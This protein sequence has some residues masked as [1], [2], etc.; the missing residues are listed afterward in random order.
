[1]IE[2]SSLIDRYSVPG[3]AVAIV[4]DG[5]RGSSTAG[6]SSTRTLNSMTVHD[7]LPLS[8]VMKVMVAMMVH[9]GKDEGLL[10]LDEDI[11]VFVPEL[12]PNP[13]GIT[14]RHLL[15]H[16]A[17]YIEPQENS[18]RWAYDWGRFVDFFPHRRQ[19]F[20]PG[21]AWSYTHTGYVLLAKTLEAV[22]K[23]PVGDLL[24]ERL[25]APLGLAAALYDAGDGAV[26]LHVRSPRTD[27]MEPMRPPAETGFLRYSIS[28]IAMSTDHLA[29]FAGALAGIYDARIPHLEAARKALL[30]PAIELPTFCHSPQSELMPLAYRLG[31]ADYGDVLGVNGSYVGST[32]SLRFCP[33]TRGGFAVSL[34]AWSPYVRDAVA[35]RATQT[36][37][38]LN[39]PPRPA[40]IDRIT[41]WEGRY[42]GLMLGSETATMARQGEALICHVA[43]KGAP[44]L[45]GQVEIAPDGQPVVVSGQSGLTLALARTGRGEPYLMVGTSAFR[46]IAA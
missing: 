35:A 22:F 44:A 33:G 36:L 4:K 10:A 41:D 23:Q 27:R 9:H 42:E 31:V 29:T 26:D 28:D 2:L 7:R 39:P 46:K 3:I 6:V 40:S 37:T 45:S 21:S 20:A 38:A 32:C 11:V 8:C 25:L 1:M 24:Q 43:R 19:A 14:L 30:E 34:N 15:S 13:S 12:G 17:G 5:R 16:T 18:A